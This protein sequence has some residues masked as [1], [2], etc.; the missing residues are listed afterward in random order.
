MDAE[1]DRGNTALAYAVLARHEG[2]ALALM[3][4]G[5]PVGVLVHPEE[6]EEEEESGRTFGLASSERPGEQKWKAEPFSIF[7]VLDGC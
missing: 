6:G 4:Q 1:D 3:Q 5:A 2:C 7:Q